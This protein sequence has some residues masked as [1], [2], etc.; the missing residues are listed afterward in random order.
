MK[1]KW[2]LKTGDTIVTDNGTYLVFSSEGF[3][4]FNDEGEKVNVILVDVER[5]SME[6]YDYNANELWKYYNIQEIIPNQHSFERRIKEGDKVR[7]NTGIEGIIS[8]IQYEFDRYQFRNVS[9]W[10][11]EIKN[12]VKID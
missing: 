6:G 7:E 10:R 12:I 11:Y 9:G 4:L 1:M 3:D 8:H 2:D 5:G